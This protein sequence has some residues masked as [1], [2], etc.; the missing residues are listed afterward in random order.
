MPDEYP[1]SYISGDIIDAPIPTKPGYVFRGW[2]TD[3]D[4]KYPFKTDTAVYSK[5]LKLYALW[6][7]DLSGYSLRHEVTG[8]RDGSVITG[9]LVYHYYHYNNDR[10]AYYIFHE[11]TEYTDGEESEKQ[12]LE[13]FEPFDNSF[14][15]DRTETIE[16]VN[17]M[18][19]CNVYAKTLFLDYEEQ[20]VGIEDGIV[21]KVVQTGKTLVGTVREHLEYELTYCHYEEEKPSVKLTVIADDGLRIEGNDVDYIKGTSVDLKAVPDKGEKFRG[22]F[23]EDGKPV[24]TDRELSLIIT[25][26]I[27][28]KAHLIQW[29]PISYE[30]GDGIPTSDL[31]KKYSPGTPLSLPYVNNGKDVF[32]GWYLDADY[33]RPFE[34]DTSLLEGE[35]TLYVKWDENLIGHTLTM[36]KSGIYQRGINTCTIEGTLTFT[37]LYYNFDK[38]SYFI[39]NSDYTKYTYTYVEGKDYE[40]NTS[41]MY[42]SSEIDGEWDYLGTEEISVVID[43]ETIQKLCHKNVLTYPSGATETQWSADGWIVYKIE[44]VYDLDP[45]NTRILTYNYLSDGMTEIEENCEITVVSGDGITISGNKSPYQLG[46]TAV[47]EAS[48][49]KNVEFGGW[50]DE[51]NTLLCSSKRYQFT[52]GGS[53][54]IFAVNSNTLDAIFESDT[55]ID[56]DQEFGLTSATYTI[57]NT[58]TLANDPDITGPYTFDD[59]GRYSIIAKDSDG[60][61]KFFTVKVTGGAERTFEW[62]F[63]NVEYTYTLDIDYDDYLYS[64]DLYDISKRKQQTPSHARDITFVT[65]SYTDERM[66]PYMETLV[67]GL[68]DTYKAENK[69]VTEQKYLGYLLAF[70]QYIEYQYDEEEMGVVEYWKFPL[71]TLYDQGGDC[72][73]TSILFIA[74]AHESRE[75]LGMDYKTALQLLP[76]HMCGAIKLSGSSSFKTNPYGYIYCE[77]TSTDYNLGQVP[78]VANM[79][80]YFLQDKYYANGR[81]HTLE[82]E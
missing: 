16:T 46:E 78:T 18:K 50:Y 30:L 75:I 80:E 45:N 67:N 47:L 43:G 15:L 2:F 13:L 52:V 44:F 31:P 57:T 6:E 73:D 82:V 27:T 60:T 68:Y 21:Y 25:D 79:K 64:K 22:W 77:T 72:E 62:I 8:E 61:S 49:D 65:K 33:E 54:T 35:I 71:E 74:L 55:E 63:E 40:E 37:Y 32:G 28:L 36:T 7:H 3:K 1:E 20:W 51:N 81:S 4:F 11:Y 10:A 48:T 19:K 14:K 38:Q 39:K 17:G 66:A 29:F 24:S 70:T 41:S 9:E 23:D 12:T 5:D 76:G 26:D 56:L 69:P 59:G 53:Q 42:W 34:G 58:D